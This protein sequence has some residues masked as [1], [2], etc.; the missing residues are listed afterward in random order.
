MLSVIPT[1]TIAM[2]AQ[3]YL[4]EGLSLGAVKG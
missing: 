3:R 1:A 2:F 4:V